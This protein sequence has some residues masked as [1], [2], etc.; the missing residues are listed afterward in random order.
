E[1]LLRL[2]VNTFPIPSGS[3][4]D[5]VVQHIGTELNL[6]GR[7]ILDTGIHRW[8]TCWATYRS[9]NSLADGLCNCSGNDFF[10]SVVIVSD[11]VGNF[12]TDETN[13]L[14]ALVIG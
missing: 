10:L 3:I 4:S 5:A 11:Y 6:S 1:P 9:W 14:F 8:I 7:Q 13:D 2:A 12:E